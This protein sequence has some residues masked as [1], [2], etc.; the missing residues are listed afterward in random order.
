M[1]SKDKSLTVFSLVMI[2]IIAIDNIRS[3]PASAEFGLSLIGYYL[4]MAI[5]FFIPIALVSAEL[6]TSLPRRGG[7]YV[8]TK[9]AFGP[10]VGCYVI[11]LQWIYNVVWYPTQMAFIAAVTAQLLP[12]NLGQNAYFIT[13]FSIAVFALS[14]LANWYGMKLSSL[15]CSIGAIL[16]TLIP[17]F[18]VTVCAMIWVINDQPL[19]INLESFHWVPNWSDQHLFGYLSL[20]MFGLVGIEMSAV[21]ADDVKNPQKSYPRAILISTVFIILSLIIASLSIAVIVPQ[22]ELNIMTGVIQAMDYVIDHS[23]A[24]SWQWIK[25]L[26][27]VFIIMGS[28][29]A[30]AAWVIGPSKGLLIAAQ[31][32]YA[33]VFLRKENQYR[34]PVNILIVQ[35]GIFALLCSSYHFLPIQTAFFLLTALT[36]QLAML[37]YLFLLASSLVIRYQTPELQGSYRIPGGFRGLCFVCFLGFIGCILGLAVGFMLPSNLEGISSGLYALI[38]LIGIIVCS[39]PPLLFKHKVINDGSNNQ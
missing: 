8:W 39:L 38:I 3:L 12:M 22:S 14:T 34:A 10:R 32:G 18:L 13:G 11:W 2:N 35:M 15:I 31:D 24:H 7:V 37:G 16:G 17:M 20:V 30:I 1:S 6:A 28:F 9:N 25:Y 26:L 23:F 21:H 5:F 33:P 29:S 27:H 4:L 36:D 19:G